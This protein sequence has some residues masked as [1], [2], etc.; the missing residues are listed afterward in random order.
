MRLLATLALTLT[1]ATAASAQRATPPS[2]A[3]FLGYEIGARFTPHHRIVDYMR[4][5]AAASPRA[6]FA[7]FG[8][9]YEGRP[10]TYLIV[11]S[12]ANMARLDT[13]RDANLRL[14]DPRRTS[15]ADAKSLAASTPVIVWLGF[16]VHGDES[17]SPEAAMMTAHALLTSDDAQLERAVVIID[18]TQN[19]DGRD[20]YVQQF[21]Q[22]RGRVANPD[23]ASWEHGN[24]WP[25]GRFN[26]YL[27]DMNRDWAW[28]SQRETRARLVELQKWNPQVFVDL[29]EMSA[30]STYFFPP[31]ANPIN[32]NVPAGTEKWLE[33]FGRANAAVFTAR[34]WPFFVSERFD[35]FYPAYGDSYPSL[36][37]AIGMTYE[38]A[39]GPRGGSLYRRVDETLLTLSHRANQHFTAA[40]T[41]ISTAAAN[42]EALHQHA[43]D[44]RR[45]ALSAPR[46]TYV[47]SRDDA[48]ALAIVRL[49]TL[50]GVE[51]G[52]LRSAARA[53]GTDI[54]TNRSETRDFP[55]GSF[56]VS[57]A[58]PLGGLVRTLFERS[59]KLQ[60]AFVAE[61][62]ERLA[63]DEEDDFYDI[64]AWSL[65]IAMNVATLATDAALVSDAA[66]LPTNVAAALPQARY[67]WALAP[68]AADYYRVIARL[69][70][71][72]VRFRVA[73]QPISRAVTRGS[74]VIERNVNGADVEERLRAAVDGTSAQLT[75]IDE[76]W[77][78]GL[79][80]GSGRMFFVRDPKIAIVGGDEFDASSFGMI[81]HTLDIELE[82][83]HSVIEVP[84]LRSRDLAKYRAVIL[85]D[86]GLDLISALGKGGVEA[87]KRWINEGGTLIAIKGS[88]ASL[89]AKEVEISKLAEWSEKKSDDKDGADD[90][91]AED[92]R[93]DYRIPGS[94]FETTMNSRS[95]LTFGLTTPPAV[96]IEGSRALTPLARKT[97]NVVTVTGKDPLVAGFAWPESIERVRNSVY[98]ARERVGRGS[99]ITFADQPY[100]RLFWRS[101]LPLLMN[102]AVFSPTFNEE[103]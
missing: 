83:P 20:R 15:P 74:V 69:L 63:A 81:W 78:E 29:H 59:P 8:E 30:E 28:A 98:L 87:L 34:Q 43:Y 40:M 3:E 50:H 49:L 57:T 62:K 85:P 95:Y 100:Y 47:F 94:A 32:A 9:S 38:V 92:R 89:R 84:T 58:Q 82:M 27:V 68:E 26:H 60:E 103:E 61:Q 53:R 72:G 10:L 6:Q 64:T 21:H 17:S 22:R 35:L 16:G 97:D 1:F 46:T 31:D 25:R 41:T 77:S 73:S 44:A 36:R 67:A 39:G 55:S 76:V 101:T 19:P 23:P 75:G 70:S 33:A 2:P 65:P 90:D 13:I 4:A 86:S 66:S 88:A 102:A 80:L 7:T 91:A 5:L 48:N 45:S 71:S 51:V 96:L 14:T 37:G 24:M 54:R 11:S 79:A 52:S 18:P 56:T 99:V 12:A 42:R 93:F